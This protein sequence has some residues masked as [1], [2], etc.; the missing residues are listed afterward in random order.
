MRI[1]RITALQGNEKHSTKNVH[2]MQNICFLQEIMSICKNRKVYQAVSGD[3]TA[4]LKLSLKKHDLKRR[5][6]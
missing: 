3:E 1:E 6:N 2:F 4:S 5:I